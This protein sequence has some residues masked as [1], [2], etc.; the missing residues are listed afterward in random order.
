MS[1]K[2]DK[3]LSKALTINADL[4]ISYSFLLMAAL[5]MAGELIKISKEHK[6]TYQI[7]IQLVT[8]YQEK[9]RKKNN[10]LKA[11]KKEPK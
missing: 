10:K 11:D 5:D 3:E 8:A 9:H 6:R 1:T 2:K 7:P 4:G